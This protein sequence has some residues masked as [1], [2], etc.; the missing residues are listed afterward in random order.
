M[1]FVLTLAVIGAA[2]WIGKL[3]ER[4]SIRTDIYTEVTKQLNYRFGAENQK[5]T[6]K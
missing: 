5:R 2:Y 1:N 6:W 4:D 3:R